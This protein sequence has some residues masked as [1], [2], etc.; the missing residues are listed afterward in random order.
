MFNA[1]KLE[2]EK[3]INKL[4]ITINNI[5]KNSDKNEL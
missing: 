2:Y 1:Q 5:Q 4:R 3:Q